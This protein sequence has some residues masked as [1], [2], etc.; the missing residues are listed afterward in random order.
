[1]KPLARLG[2]VMAYAAL[3]AGCAATRAASSNVAALPGIAAPS[4]QVGVPQPGP[5]LSV[6]SS[7]VDNMPET[8]D[9]YIE[10]VH[11][12][13]ARYDRR[14]RHRV[15]DGRLPEGA[16]FEANARRQQIEQL[17]SQGMTDGRL[18]R[19]ERRWINELLEHQ[20]DVISRWERAPTAVG[21][22]P[23]SR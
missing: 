20:D 3:A 5:R 7:T 10:R 17:L 14:I 8:S 2:I 15:A 23:R 16:L 12:Q 4:P 9:V 21:G 13:L 18:D 19:H 1:M 22:G 11:E 6:Y